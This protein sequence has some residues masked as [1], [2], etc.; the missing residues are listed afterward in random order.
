MGPNRGYRRRRAL[1]LG[2]EGTRDRFSGVCWWW[3]KV[4]MN[5]VHERSQSHKLP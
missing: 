4:A 5:R 1:V 3:N 2:E